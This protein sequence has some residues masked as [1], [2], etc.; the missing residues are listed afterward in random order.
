MKSLSESVDSKAIKAHE[1]IL[2][3]LMLNNDKHLNYI[4]I[5]LIN[6][7]ALFKFIKLKYISI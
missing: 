2:C 5:P 1:F 7:K 3:A 4:G 6:E